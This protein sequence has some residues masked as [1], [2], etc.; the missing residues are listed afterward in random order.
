[1]VG[2]LDGGHI[3]CCGDGHYWF[4]LYGGLL[5]E[6]PSNQALYPL[7]YG[8][9]LRLRVPSLRSC[10]VGPPRSAIHG[11]TRLTRHPCRVA[12]CAEPAL[13]LSTG[14]G[15]SKAKAKAKAKARRPAAG[16]PG[17]R[18]CTQFSV[19]ASLLAKNA[20]TTCSSR[21]PASSLTSIASRLAPTG[22]RGRQPKPGRLSGRL[23]LALAFDLLAPS[24]GRVEVLR[25]GQTGMDA[26]LAAAGHG[27]PMAAGPRSRTG[28]RACRA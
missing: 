25:S 20:Q 26:G 1:M 28:R 15:R 16:R 27:W 18:G 14:Q 13:G 5:G 17:Y 4:R 22:N 6:A 12:H 3:H 8:P 19:G 24:R 7:T 10:S 21:H 2:F 23:A 11:R 9:S